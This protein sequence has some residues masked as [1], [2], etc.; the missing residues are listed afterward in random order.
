MPPAIDLSL[1]ELR[2]YKPQLTKRNDFDDFWEE[3]LKE[4]EEYPLDSKLEEYNYPVK[5]VKVYNAYYNGFKGTRINGWYVLPPDA[6][7][8]HKVPVLIRYHG[9]TGNKAYVQECLKWSIQGCAVLTVNVRGQ[10]GITPDTAIY[11]QGGI[12]G[13][14]TLG[15]LD[16]YQYYYRN[17]YMECVR[18]IDFV[19]EREEIDSGQIGVLGVSQGGGLSMAVCA[20]DKRPG[21][22]MPVYPYLCHFERAME[23]YQEGPY[24]ELFDYF[25]RFD[26]EMLTRDKVFETL[27]YF[28]SMNMAPMIQCPVLMA[29]GLR[30]LTCPPSTMFAAYNH[31]NCE[32]ELKIYPH[33][34]HEILPF[35]DEAMIGFARKFIRG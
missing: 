33:H 32:K 18:A 12:K 14:M 24:S 2:E 22:A 31:L 6:S 8:D 1:D 27:S 23:M 25:R 29:I 7:K 17:V 9:Y 15:I 13:W 3:T 20:L 5:E 16:K 28:D 26:P 34:G 19:C 30:D 21:F 35:H 11:S 4:N 10:G